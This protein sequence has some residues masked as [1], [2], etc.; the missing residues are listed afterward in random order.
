MNWKEYLTEQLNEATKP[1]KFNQSKAFN[2]AIKLLDSKDIEVDKDKMMIKFK[3]DASRKDLFNKMGKD[4]IKK[5]T[6]W[7][8]PSIWA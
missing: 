8:G 2:D 3:N 5:Y 6:N 7:K 1:L 4:E